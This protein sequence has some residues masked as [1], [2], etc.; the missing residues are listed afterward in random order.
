MANRFVQEHGV[1]R[2]S[3]GEAIRKILQS[4]PSC[5]LVEEINEH[6]FKGMMV[7]DELATEA[8]EL[9]LLDPQCVTRG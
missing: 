7:P 2:L 9:Y 3:I 5:E 1:A 8:L 4:H 6:L